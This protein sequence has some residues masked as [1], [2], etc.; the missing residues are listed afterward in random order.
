MKRMMLISATAGALALGFASNVQAAPLSTE[1]TQVRGLTQNV[2]YRRCW[3]HDGR[4]VCRYVYGYR[5]EEWRHHR[6][7]WRWRHWRHRHWD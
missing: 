7:W 1:P 5:N 6:P 3:W 4:R 2:D